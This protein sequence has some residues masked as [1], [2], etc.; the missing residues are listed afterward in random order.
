MPKYILTDKDKKEI[1]S[2]SDKFTAKQLSEQYGCSRSTI[3]KI[4]MDNDY[5]K[6]RSFSYYVNDNYF[7]E[8]KRW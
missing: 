7:S 2:K 1:L 3:L 6:P 5:H 8:I 4:W